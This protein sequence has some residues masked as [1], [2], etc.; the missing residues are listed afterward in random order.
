M[1][2]KD[3]DKEIRA[4]IG[5][6]DEPDASVYHLI[7]QQL[8]QMG[9]SVIPFLEE[10]W[11]NTFDPEVQ[12]RIEEIIHQIQF[13]QLKTEFENWKMVSPDDLMKGFLLVSRYHYPEISEAYLIEQ[14]EQMKW[15]I[16]LELNDNLTALEKIKVVNHVM[17]GIHKFGANINNANAL[18]NF[19]LN[20][21]LETQRGNS[22]S[23]GILYLI[24]C[25]KLAIP[26]YGV[27]LP[28]HFVLGY[29]REIR[30]D[31]E[32]LASDKQQVL[33]YIN[34]VKKGIAFTRNEIE[35]YL[36]HLQV[37]TIPDYFTACDNLLVI[38]RLI[39]DLKESYRSF[40]LEEKV[41]ELEIIE[42]ILQ[43]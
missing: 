38:K 41:L 30:Q 39:R 8:L 16:W 11:E 24:L 18:Q 9:H 10:A 25:Q 23:I 22:V 5:L 36:A 29:T 21:V 15:E 28:N 37:E 20:N 4:L 17:Y 13:I 43:E 32:L 12:D 7:K 14:I 6:L 27:D 3:I 34:P 40:N 33:F 26:V 31:E 1:D 19:F 2:T 42:E 35:L